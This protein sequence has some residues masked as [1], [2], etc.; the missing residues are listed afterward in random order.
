MPAADRIHQHSQRQ[1]VITSLCESPP[2][3]RNMKS[4]VV[5]ATCSDS[6]PKICNSPPQNMLLICIL[7]SYMPFLLILLSS[8]TLDM[9]L[10]SSSMQSQGRHEPRYYVRDPW[11]HGQ[12]VCKTKSIH[13]RDRGLQNFH[14][15]RVCWLESSLPL[16]TWLMDGWQALNPN[17]RVMDCK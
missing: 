9:N 17:W 3:R 12:E 1:D 13:R 7:P 4:S 10:T 2:Q 6:R 15:K 11:R 16:R 5:Y 14:P 8:S